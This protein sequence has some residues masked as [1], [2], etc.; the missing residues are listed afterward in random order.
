MFPDANKTRAFMVGK[1]LHE[2]MS[3][4]LKIVTGKITIALMKIFERLVLV[5]RLSISRVLLLSWYND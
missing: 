3:G 2:L 1:G 5:K 4:F